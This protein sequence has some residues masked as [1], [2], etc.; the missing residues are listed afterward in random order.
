M[1]PCDPLSVWAFLVSLSSHRDTR[2][3]GLWPHFISLKLLF[4][5]IVTLGV[6]ASCKLGDG[7]EQNLV[8]STIL[9]S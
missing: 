8:H 1:S 7:W 3:I 9:A 6:R 2:P 4:L 5:N